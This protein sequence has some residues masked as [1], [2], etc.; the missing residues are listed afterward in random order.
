[1]AL[2]HRQACKAA[3]REPNCRPGQM[4]GDKEDY[5][6][7]PSIKDQVRVRKSIIGGS[8]VGGFLFS[9]NSFKLCLF[10]LG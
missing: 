2:Y 6:K 7:G 1:M 10:F 8:L 4:K 3:L 5:L 9:H